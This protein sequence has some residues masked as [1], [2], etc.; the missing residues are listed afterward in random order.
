MLSD[1]GDQLLYRHKFDSACK[2]ISLSDELS[3]QRQSPMVGF[4]LA[5][6]SIGVIELMRNRCQV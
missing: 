6:G 1:R 5:N 4:G 3:E 2:A